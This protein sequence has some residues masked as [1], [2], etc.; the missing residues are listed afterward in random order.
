MSKTI[1]A[2]IDDTMHTMI[3]DEANQKGK[4]VNESLKEML[5]NHFNEEEEKE[6]PQS[7]N[8]GLEQ[9]ILENQ[10]NQEKKI[11][12]MNEIL[13][14]IV[15]SLKVIQ[16][17]TLRAVDQRLEDHERKYKHDMKCVD[18]GLVCNSS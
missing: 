6:I 14:K 17:N 5:N 9:E 18:N 4:T 11:E 8:E 12:G 16:G 10:N 2:R 7:Q 1:S 3:T 13:E 15:D